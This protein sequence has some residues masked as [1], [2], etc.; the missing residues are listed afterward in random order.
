MTQQ[1][2]VNSQAL[3]NLAAKLEQLGY[4]GDDVHDVAE[5]L[6]MNL[7]AD[8]YRRLDPVPDLRPTSLATAAQR[9]RHLEAIRAELA[10][11]QRK[12]QEAGR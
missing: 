2:A 9:A 10:A 8:G 11:A 6:A 5:R 4:A 7:L 3:I 12:T 1:I